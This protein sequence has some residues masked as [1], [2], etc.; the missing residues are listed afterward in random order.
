MG[1]RRPPRGR[2]RSGPRRRVQLRTG[3]P[4]GWALRHGCAVCGACR[5]SVGTNA[6]PVTASCSRA[7]G[8]G[9]GGAS[10][11]SRHSGQWS[12]CSEEGRPVGPRSGSPARSSADSKLTQRRPSGVQISA[13][14]LSSGEATANNCDTVGRRLNAQ[15]A[16][17]AIQVGT[18][19]HRRSDVTSRKRHR[20]PVTPL[21]CGAGL[22]V[23]PDS[24]R[25]ST[26]RRRKATRWTVQTPSLGSSAALRAGRAR[27]KTGSHERDV[28]AA[29]DAN[30]R[31]VRSNARLK[32]RVRWLWS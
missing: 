10:C 32:W 14:R 24:A 22:M 21:R 27:V 29:S 17:K 2:P 8:T 6:G 9:I 12:V 30:E 13:R 4:R 11:C 18:T 20:R 26:K 3:G 7:V 16:S 31:G 5:K 1:P 15:I 28:S 19:L 23:P 25:T